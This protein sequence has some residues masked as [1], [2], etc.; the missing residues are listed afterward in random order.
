MFSYVVF[1]LNH[2]H[3]ST[4]NPTGHTHTPTWDLHSLTWIGRFI[5]ANFHS[6]PMWGPR[7]HDHWKGGK[8]NSHFTHFFMN[9]TDRKCIVT[10]KFIRTHIASTLNHL[11]LSHSYFIKILFALFKAP[12][13]H[14]WRLCSMGI[15]NLCEKSAPAGFVKFVWVSKN[16]GGF[17]PSN[18]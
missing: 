9:Q 1:F 8:R 6:V 2:T 13:C 14:K 16:L 3:P 5:Y 18:Y 17:L 15:L 11:S 7:K 4:R 10:I 12:L